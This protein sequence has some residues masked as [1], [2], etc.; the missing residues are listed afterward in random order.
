MFDSTE[1]KVTAYH[2]VHRKVVVLGL[3][4][5]GVLVVPPDLCVTREE[6]PLVVHDPVEHLHTGG[7]EKT[8][9]V[10]GITLE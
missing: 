7:S 10:N 3:Q 2:A 8:P 9:K 6:K 4:L 5:D 1:T